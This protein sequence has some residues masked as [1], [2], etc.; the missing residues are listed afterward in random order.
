[1]KVVYRSY[2]PE[3]GLDEFQAR[4]YS[5]AS[6]LPARAEEIRQRNLSRE[7]Q[8]TRYALTEKGEPLAYI[9]SRDSSSE[10]G[11]TYIGYP[12]ALPGAPVE[13]QEKLFND[14][15]G[16]LKKRENTLEIATSIVLTAK[17]AD[18]QIEYFQNKGFVEKQRLYRYNLDYDVNVVSSWKL[19][20]EISAFTSRVA[21]TEDLNHLIELSQADPYLQPAFPTPETR[22]S[23]FKDRV[24]K[25]G[26]AVIIFDKDQAVA[27]SAALRFKPNQL[28]LT[29]DEERT[30]MRFTA[31]RP[32]YS[33]AWK[34]LL[35]EIAKEAKT[36]GWTNI[37][38]RVSFSFL[39]NAPLA[40]NLAE[41][42]PELEVFEVILALPNKS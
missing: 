26:H 25:D 1:M 8:M 24:L 7:P 34:R 28:F 14:L 3:Q 19:T 6:G 32:G 42:R 21:A 13:A 2:E 37:P 9:T 12:W 38:L 15:L 30:I 36:A 11:R 33:H 5:E 35:I 41:L 4:I 39:T 22:E 16:Y 10:V 20:K 17:I 40:I 18:K 23:Y 27:A 31:L 29:G